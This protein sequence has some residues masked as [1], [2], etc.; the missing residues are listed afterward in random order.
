MNRSKRSIQRISDQLS[1]VDKL[2]K[3]KCCLFPN[4]LHTELLII[5]ILFADYF[6]AIAWCEFRQKAKPCGCRRKLLQPFAENHTMLTQFLKLSLQMKIDFHLL[7]G[8]REKY[9]RFCAAKL[10]ANR[11][12]RR[13]DCGAGD[14]NYGNPERTPR[15]EGITTPSGKWW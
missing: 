14:G 7:H 13:D 1:V 6:D 11:G 5:L 15:S 3:C 8:I 12:L 4:C 9:P 2:N 10:R